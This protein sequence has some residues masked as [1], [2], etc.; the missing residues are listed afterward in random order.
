MVDMDDNYERSIDDAMQEYARKR[1]S[2]DALTRTRAKLHKVSE[3]LLEVC[4]LA[5]D[6]DVHDYLACAFGDWQAEVQG[7]L[8]EVAMTF[9]IVA[10]D[11]YNTWNDNKRGRQSWDLTST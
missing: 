3:L 2:D 5:A 11:V 4:E 10:T 1:K 8:D 7:S 9:Q 6:D